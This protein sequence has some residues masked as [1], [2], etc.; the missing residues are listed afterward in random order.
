MVFLYV[1]VLYTTQSVISLE[2]VNCDGL[3]FSSLYFKQTD[4]YLAQQESP[5]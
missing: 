3:V 5:Q 4:T 1:K 2:L